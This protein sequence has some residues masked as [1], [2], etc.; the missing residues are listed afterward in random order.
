MTD[1]HPT[2]KQCQAL[3]KCVSMRTT[4][5][6]VDGFN[7]PASRELAGDDFDKG[8]PCPLVNDFLDF[9]PKV[10][11]DFTFQMTTDFFV[12]ANPE[13][14]DF[15]KGYI[16]GTLFRFDGPQDRVDS[17]V[18]LVLN[19]AKNKMIYRSGRSMVPLSEPK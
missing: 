11:G 10:I 4:N 8:I 17:F 2:K 18:D 1:K 19:L 6:F 9:L 5:R 15:D 12:Y 14:E 13:E 16:P 3:L 7:L